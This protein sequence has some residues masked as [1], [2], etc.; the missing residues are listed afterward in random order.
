MNHF[1]SHFPNQ[2]DKVQFDYLVLLDMAK[3]TCVDW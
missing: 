3:T 1:V 2:N